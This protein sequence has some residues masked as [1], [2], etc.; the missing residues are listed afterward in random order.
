MN[1]LYVVK[2]FGRYHYFKTEE[3]REAY[4]N[5]LP[6]WEAKYCEL[7]AVRYGKAV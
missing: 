7:Y 4:L 1:T 5:T 3:A 6:E 2:N